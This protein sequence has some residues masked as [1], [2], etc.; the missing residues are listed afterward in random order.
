MRE[1]DRM[2]K[3]RE[4]VVDQQAGDRDDSNSGEATAKLGTNFTS[5]FKIWDWSLSAM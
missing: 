2:A 4:E 5:L 1:E 3:N